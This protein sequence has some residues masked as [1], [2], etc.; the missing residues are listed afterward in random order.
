[1]ENDDRPRSCVAHKLYGFVC[2]IILVLRLETHR[3]RTACRTINAK[4]AISAGT[5]LSTR[6]QRVCSLPN[7]A[8]TAITGLHAAWTSQ[9]P[10]CYPPHRR[11]SMPLVPC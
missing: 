5:T 3:P 2:V 10:L 7:N 6:R 1:M 9:I 4:G 8:D 11:Y